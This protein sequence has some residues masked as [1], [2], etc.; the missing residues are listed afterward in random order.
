MRCFDSQFW[1]NVLCRILCNFIFSTVGLMILFSQYLGWVNIPC[2]GYN[3]AQ[4]WHRQ[5][6]PVL[7]MF[8]VSILSIFSM[9]IYLFIYIFYFFYF[10]FLHWNV[11][12][13]DSNYLE[14][15]CFIYCHWCV[16]LL[17]NV[18]PLFDISTI[19]NFYSTSPTMH[20]WH[21]VQENKAPA[22]RYNVLQHRLAL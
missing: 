16:E 8:P 12:W 4:G 10:F 19:F 3:K 18:Q 7:K 2:C 17:K 11:F 6:Y 20:L 22:H 5:P 1:F 9:C 13:L 14:K 15:F 21:L